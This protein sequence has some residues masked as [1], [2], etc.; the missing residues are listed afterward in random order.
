MMLKLSLLFPVLLISWL[1]ND[2]DARSI[3][4]TQATTATTSNMNKIDSFVDPSKNSKILDSA[5]YDTKVKNPEY[6]L[7]Q[8]STER[9]SDVIIATKPKEDKSDFHQGLKSIIGG[10]LIHLTLGTCYCWGN[11]QSYAPL[12]LKFFDGKD[13]PGETPDSTLALPVFFIGQCLGM[14][15]GPAIVKAIGARMT[16]RL[17][18][19]SVLATVY[20]ASYTKTLATFLLFYGLLFGI[21]VGITYTA[22]MMAAYT[23]LPKSKGLVSGAIL[24]GYGMGGFFFNIIGTKFANPSGIDPINGVFPIEIYSNF[25]IM[26]RRLVIIY[27]ILQIIGTSIITEKQTKGPVI[28]QSGVKLF[29]A[30]K[31]YPFWLLWLMIMSTS[32]AGLN[33]A[34]MYKQFASYHIELNGDRYQAL[35][36]GMGSMFNGGGRLLWGLFSDKVGFKNAFTLLTAI[37]TILQVLFPFCCANN[38]ILFFSGVCMSYFLLAGIFSMTPPVVYNLYGSEDAAQIYGLLYSAFGTASVLSA[39]LSKVRHDRIVEYSVQS[40]YAIYQYYGIQYTINM[41]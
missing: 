34:S 1:F 18:C 37:Q 8:K 30:L 25:P 4:V 7:K 15:F 40:I 22:P 13:H 20:I 23:W 26:L 5:S 32:S 10:I 6:L 41:V 16:A 33:I 12:G 24:G 38:K 11:F 19:I 2:I 9:L 29:D 17:G 28:K 31:T 14:P 36:G 3:D 21:S 27:A 35:V 39:M